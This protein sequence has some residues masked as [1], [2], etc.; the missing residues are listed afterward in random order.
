MLRALAAL[1]AL[2]SILLF[3]YGRLTAPADVRDTVP[4]LF[5]E[6][7]AEE[8]IYAGDRIR[9]TRDRVELANGSGVIDSGPLTGIYAVDADD[10][11][12]Q[13]R[14]EYGIADQIGAITVMLDDRG[15]LRLANR[16]ATAWQRSVSGPS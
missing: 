8:G 3:A 13:Y 7:V 2:L 14:V 6:W 10:G 15:Q 9:I 5:G 12:A 16:P 4:N 1:A 11:Y